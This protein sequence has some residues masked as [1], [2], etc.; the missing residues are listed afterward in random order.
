MV[1]FIHFKNHFINVNHI[2][3]IIFSE[4]QI[5]FG[6]SHGELKFS[7]DSYDENELKQ[8]LEDIQ[9]FM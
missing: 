8:L 9:S 1:K 6:F 5:Y 2:N 7:C 4:K 3:A